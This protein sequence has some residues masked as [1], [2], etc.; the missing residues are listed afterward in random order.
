MVT[1][2]L[3]LAVANLGLGFA[4]AIALDRFPVLSMQG[5]GNRNRLT[6][7]VRQDSELGGRTAGNGPKDHLADADIEAKSAIERLLWIVK[8]ET[9]LRRGRLIELDEVLFDHPDSQPI[10][11][12]L[13]QELESF[14]QQL[15]AWMAELDAEKAEAG[16]FGQLLEELLVDQAVQWRACTE[17]LA[18]VGGADVARHLMTATNALNLLR[19]Q[20]DALLC[21]LLTAEDRLHCIGDRYRTYG[22]RNTLTHLGL[23]AL[24]DEWWADDPD[25]VRMVS[26]AMLDLDHFESYTRE[27]GAARG[28]LALLRIGNLLHDLVRKDRGFDRVA[29]YSGQRFVLFLG[30]TS[31]KNAA[32]GAERFRQTIE[33]TTLK[34]GN[35]TA[36]V[37]ASVG[38]VEVGK[39]EGPGDFMP[40]LEAAL[41]AGKEAGR[42]CGFVDAGTGP[43]PINLPRFQVAASVIELDA[44]HSLV[45]A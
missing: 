45:T 34:S 25:H 13:K 11:T 37:T 12:E 19:D 23:A 40:R 16:T 27:V 4:L 2:V 3:A 43:A 36:T 39:V 18:E 24:F 17:E 41:K 29:R 38:V 22:E 20:T 44:K 30:D 33:A 21:Q 9:R 28:D 31:A 1:I 26:V 35:E 32:K 8:L 14:H 10:A 6:S 7:P 15:E 5:T 42:N